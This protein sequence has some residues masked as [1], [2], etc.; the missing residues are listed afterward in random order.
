MVKQGETLLQLNSD[1]ATAN[2]TIAESR[3]ADSQALVRDAVAQKK[4]L[5]S[6]GSQISKADIDKS[7]IALSR[8]LAAKNGAEAQV[9]LATKQLSDQTISAP[10]SGV[11]TSIRPSVGELLPQAS[12]PS[13]YWR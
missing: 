5:A 10:F 4:R 7:A 6:L 3:L 13:E 11:V 12:P 8:A 9:D 1:K 2:K